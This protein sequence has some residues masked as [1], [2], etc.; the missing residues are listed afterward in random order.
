MCTQIRDMFTMSKPTS[1]YEDLHKNQRC[2]VYSFSVMFGRSFVVLPVLLVL[3]GVVEG[4]YESKLL[5]EVLIEA[6]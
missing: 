6:L 5:I 3:L 4:Q 2:V 1:I